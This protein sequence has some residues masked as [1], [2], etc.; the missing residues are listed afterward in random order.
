MTADILI[1]K[2]E[3]LRKGP[4][5]LPGNG[6]AEAEYRLAGDQLA[7]VQGRPQLK[8]KYRGGN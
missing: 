7:R 2:M 5:L 8:A 3:R 1:K 6:K 4:I